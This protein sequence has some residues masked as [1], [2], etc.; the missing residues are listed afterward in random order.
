VAYRKR[1]T[2][3]SLSQL[4][5]HFVSHECIHLPAVCVLFFFSFVSNRVA[6]A[7]YQ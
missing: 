6:H 7:G 2:A 3:A 1:K 5:C 4:A